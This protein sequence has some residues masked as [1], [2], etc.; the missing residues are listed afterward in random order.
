MD[1]HGSHRY[2]IDSEQD[3]TSDA[4]TVSDEESIASRSEEEVRFGIRDSRDL[5]ANRGEM[6]REKS[7]RSV[8]DPLLVSLPKCV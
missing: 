6:K 4:V 8:K 3:D 7:S 2:H 1:D 5:E